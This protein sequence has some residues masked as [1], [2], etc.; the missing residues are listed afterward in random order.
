MPHLHPSSTTFEV[1]KALRIRDGRD[2]AFIAA[3]ET[4]YPA[5]KAA[6]EMEQSGYS[7]RLISMHT[8]KPLDVEAVI[9]AAEEC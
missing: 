8:I 2:I 5:L 6:E 4:V 7:C 1:G 3:G 9:R